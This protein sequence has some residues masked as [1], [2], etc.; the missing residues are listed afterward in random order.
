MEFVIRTPIH[1]D[2]LE[3]LFL[4]I[5]DATVIV[6]FKNTNIACIDVLET[7]P[8]LEEFKLRMNQRELFDQYFI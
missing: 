3:D 7:S 8:P 1:P 5:F 4:S 6:W 2:H